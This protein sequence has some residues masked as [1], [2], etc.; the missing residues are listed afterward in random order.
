MKYANGTEVKLGE[1]VRVSSGY[2]GVVVASMD[3]N[4]FDHGISADDWAKT[5]IL[6]LTDTGALAHFEDPLDSKLFTRDLPK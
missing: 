3:T 2:T 5:G 6:I 1:R 4:E